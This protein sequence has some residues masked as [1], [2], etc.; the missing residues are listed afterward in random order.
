MDVL[1]LDIGGSHVKARQQFRRDP[2]VR[3]DI[4]TKAARGFG[5]QE[6]IDRLLAHDLDH[7]S[8]NESVSA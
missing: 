2:A 1:V 8:R 7:V 5:F 3:V 4:V 6:L